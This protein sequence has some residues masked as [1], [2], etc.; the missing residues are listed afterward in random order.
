MKKFLL[1]HQKLIIIL[2]LLVF[3]FSTNLLCFF[4]KSSFD[5]NK[6]VGHEYSSAEVLNFPK[7]FLW[8]AATAS[9]QVE[10]GNIYSNWW[11]FEQEEGKIKNGDRTDVA[12]DH[13]DLYE[14]DFDLMNQMNLNSYRFSIEWSRI[15]NEKGVFNN[16]EVEHY[17]N[18]IIALRKRG[19]EPMVTLW[20]HSLPTWFENEGG[21]E[22]EE[23]IKYY[24]EYVSFVLKNLSDEVDF[25]LTMNEPMAYISCGYISGKWP[26]AKQDIS[27]VKPL[28]SNLVQ[29]HK[30]AYE[31][32]HSNDKNAKVGI[33]EHSSYAVPYH[34]NNLIE[35]E[36]TYIIDYFWT[37]YLLEKVKGELDFIGL[38]YYYRQYINIDLV[39][40]LANQS[41]ADFEEQSMDRSYY[42]EGLFEVLVR[43][44][45]YDLPIYITEIGVPDYH[46]IDRDQFI[47]EHLI[48][49]HYA[50]QA[51]VD[52]KGFYY[53]AL[54]D[55][56]EW[57]EGYDAKFGLI[58]VDLETLKRSIKQESWEYAESAKCSCVKQVG[59]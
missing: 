38:H 32:I 49:V 26:P 6:P 4:I 13:Y 34:K 53:W 25:W 44:K 23:N 58:A 41:L 40:N 50:L 30:R 55:S 8:G 9:Y 36:A 7:D 56:F 21:W 35:N 29:A 19:I 46:E 51:G 2:F 10:G 18:V 54:L 27:K 47:I 39:K 28:F 57:N 12:L 17:K 20:H 3:F 42:P 1:K 45:K 11:K 33:A 22:K 43:M 16:E 24:E 52:V 5:Y 14:Q 37:H 59:K 15:E 48:E 31:I